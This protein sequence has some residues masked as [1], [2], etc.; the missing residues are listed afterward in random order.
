MNGASLAAR[1][2]VA[3]R[4]SANPQL[5]V[6]TLARTRLAYPSA[7]PLILS[8]AAAGI[9]SLL[10]FPITC[11]IFIAFTSRYFRRS[12]SD[13]S[14]YFLPDGISGVVVE[15]PPVLVGVIVVL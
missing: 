7:K 5:P 6:L 10:L 3:C 2:Y 1:S 13:I 9:C 11:A 8:I 12:A 14:R 15:V 4:L